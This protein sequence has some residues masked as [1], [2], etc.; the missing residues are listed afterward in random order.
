MI[1][2]T[3]NKTAFLNALRITKQAIGSKI[4][5]PVLSKLKI[6]VDKEGILLTASNGQ[7]SIEKL[8]PK[9]DKDSGMLIESEGIILLEANFFDGIISQ[10]PEITFEFE[11]IENEQVK[12]RSGKSEMTLKGQSSE[13]YP[14]IQQISS[15]PFAKIK[16][17][18]LKEIFNE[19]VFSASTQESRPIL[20]GVHLMLIEHQNLIAVATDSHRLS[21][22]YVKLEN[23]GED[24]EVVLPRGAVNGFRNVFSNDEEMLNIYLS[25]TQVLFKTIDTN[26]YSRL[27]E[28]IYPDTDRLIPEESLYSL[29][30][31]F[32][33]AD[34]AHAMSRAKLMTSGIQNG[35]VR[36]SVNED[37]VSVSVNT[38]EIGSSF[39]ELSILDKSGDDID[40][41]FNPQ[42]LS[43]ALKV[44]KE[45]TVSI[46][47]ISPVRPF[48]I[49]PKEDG[50]SFIQL[51][52]P[53]RTN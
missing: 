48:T 13:L 43:D 37:H 5:I 20:T 53:V 35:T 47:F 44:I 51:I 24:F 31:T 40:I 9:N 28:G 10:L 34:L 2:F 4:A 46:R 50:T 12:I 52:T 22:R 29:D 18:Q 32:D 25:E 3:I 16:S 14:L 23:F 30:M 17:G 45:P 36:L 8:L 33:V 21:Q 1:K 7:I 39:E 11:E 19:T 6:T 27:V 26:F 49:I 38:P 15:K 41:S 42:F